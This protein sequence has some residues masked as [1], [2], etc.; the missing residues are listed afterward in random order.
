MSLELLQDIH[1]SDEEFWTSFQY[2]WKN[3]NYSMALDI[4]KENQELVT[5]YVD[6]EWF[7][8]LTNFI[9]YLETLPDNLNKKRIVVSYFPPDLDSGDVWFQLD[10]NGVKIN[11]Y[12]NFI[13]PNSTS[14]TINYSDKLIEALAFKNNELALINETIDETNHTVTFS[15]DESLDKA[16]VCM[17]YSTANSSVV[18]KTASTSAS[19]SPKTF[20]ITYTGTLLSIMCLNSSGVRSMNNLTINNSSVGFN[21]YGNPEALTGRIVYIP[22]N[23]LVNILNT[24]STVFSNKTAVLPCNGYLVN[25]FLKQTSSNEVLLGD[26]NLVLKNLV[27]DVLQNINTSIECKIYYT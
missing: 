6:A 21:L 26:I 15:L 17:V 20:S 3:G 1:F 12:M 24:Q 10:V 4:L 25:S 23:Q 5:K 8:S 7:N 13:F 14:V 27:V 2:Y 11:V 18:V 19:S 22:T 16:V 9:Y